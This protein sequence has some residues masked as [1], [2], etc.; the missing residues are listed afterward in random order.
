VNDLIQV[1]KPDCDMR[2]QVAVRGLL[3]NLKPQIVVNL[4][5]LVGGILVNTQRPAEFFYDNIMIGS[6]MLHESWRA[7]VEKYL[8]CMCG[9]S[10]PDGVPSPIREDMLWDGLPEKNSA[11][12]GC[13]KRLLPVQSAAYRCQYGFNS[14]VLVP[15]N[16]YGPHENFNLNNAHVIPSLIRK[17]YEAKRD[18]LA[19][20][21]VW[22]SGRP[23]RD[24]VY[25]GDA[26][27]AIVLALERYDGPEIINI[28]SG[29]ETMIKELVE[30]IAELFQYRGQIYWDGSKPDGQ[31]KK[32]FDVTR[33]RQL[34]AYECRT[35]LREG[36]KK[37][38]AWFEENCTKG[39]VRL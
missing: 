26:A 14:I 32:V 1:D 4:A 27:E 22:G 21:N 9:C 6:V 34:L 39:A 25:A 28:S 3:S 10:Y 37:T 19:R 8:A 23:V 24:F 29:T 7:G 17:V 33:M 16:I 5:G 11:P 12:Y 36:L 35:T 13:A 15:G 2:D 31:E 18:N 38:I 20:V 30:I